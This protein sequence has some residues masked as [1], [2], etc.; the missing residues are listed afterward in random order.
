VASKP[1]TSG[2]ALDGADR[3]ALN[4]NYVL[5]R[6]K[7]GSNYVVPE[8]GSVSFAMASGEAYVKDL[9]LQT[10]TAASVQNGLLTFNFDKATFATQL[11]VLTSG[12]RFVLA[13]NGRIGKD[14]VFSA[15]SNYLPASNMNVTGV[16][17]SENSATY[18][19]DAL[20]DSRRTVAG[21]A[22]WRKK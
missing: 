7:T 12:D 22:L 10:K 21:M 2:V 5:F 4:D 9:S 15:T 6:S 17:S 8:K 20:L 1:A 19:F 16:I 18:L 13:N 3:I 11:D 14:A